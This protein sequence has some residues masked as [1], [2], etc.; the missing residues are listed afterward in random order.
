MKI[1]Q[2]MLT[3]AIATLACSMTATV[4]AEGGK[5]RGGDRLPPEILE[6]FDADDDG[7]LS[8]DERKAMRAAIEERRKAHK[9]KILERFDADNDGKL[10]EDE[11]KAAREAA[12]AQREEI[13]A[14]VLKK[15]D[16]NGNGKIDDDER[17]GIRE[18]VKENYPDAIHRP[19]NRK[20]GKGNCSKKDG[21]KGGKGGPRRGGKPAPV[22]AD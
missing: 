13:R 1:T 2:L 14:A 6:K 22:P 10:S 16:A 19:K 20:G 18:W 7:K 5:G 11:K 9:A 4:Y 15:F 8:E 12:K 21:P 3:G 17:E